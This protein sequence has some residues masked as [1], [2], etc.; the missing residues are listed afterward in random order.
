MKGRWVIAAA[1]APRDRPVQVWSARCRGSL[2]A[3][4]LFASYAFSCSTMAILPFPSGRLLEWVPELLSWVLVAIRRWTLK[5]DVFE[6]ARSDRS[7]VRRAGA[8]GRW[9]SF[10]SHPPELQSYLN[11]WDVLR[12]CKAAMVSILAS[13]LHQPVMGKTKPRRTSF[14]V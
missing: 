1:E 7:P 9:V 14:D 4:E 6:A 13:A 12:S 2:E 11:S 8:S 3:A 10:N 5:Q